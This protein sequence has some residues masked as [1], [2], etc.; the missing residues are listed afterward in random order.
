M[1]VVKRV[2]ARGL[3]CPMP[4]VRMKKAMDSIQSG[5][6][7]ELLATDRG[8]LSDVRAWAQNG[9]HQL[10]ESREEGDV[11]VFVIRKA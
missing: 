8:S 5:E 9:G 10:L 7:V 2:D 1:E 4:V 11:F 6:V 3:S